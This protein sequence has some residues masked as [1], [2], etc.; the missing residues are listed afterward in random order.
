MKIFW[1]NKMKDMWW[2]ILSVIALLTLVRVVQMTRDYYQRN[3][4]LTMLIEN[5]GKFPDQTPKSEGLEQ[6]P[7]ATVTTWQ[8]IGHLT[9]LPTWLSGLTVNEIVWSC[10]YIAMSFF[11]A[12]YGDMANIKRWSKTTGLVVYAQF[13]SVI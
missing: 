13:P 6:L 7:A 10:L 3:K 2:L 5:G 8:T 12:F 1:A 9:R 11:V 4:R